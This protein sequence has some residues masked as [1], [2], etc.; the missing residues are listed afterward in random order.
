MEAEEKLVGSLRRAVQDGDI[1]SGSFMAGQ[2]AGL[3]SDIKT[4]K[5]VME[6]IMKEFFE[7]LKELSKYLEG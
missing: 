2:S 3:I 4:V 1:G 7:T 6:D 5:E